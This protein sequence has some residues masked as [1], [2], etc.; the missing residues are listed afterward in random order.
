MNTHDATR[1]AHGAK[2]SREVSRT[3]TADNVH[4]KAVAAAEHSVACAEMNEKCC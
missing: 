2:E 1:K 4:C 3:Y